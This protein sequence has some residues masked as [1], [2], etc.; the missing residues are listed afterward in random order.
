M[1]K[2]L[3]L[4]YLFTF[5]FLDLLISKKILFHQTDTFVYINETRHDFHEFI[6][7]KTRLP[8]DQESCQVDVVEVG[9]GL[10]PKDW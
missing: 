7:T 9:L 2:S 4:L 10:R 3:G 6:L 5:I 8:M 1:F